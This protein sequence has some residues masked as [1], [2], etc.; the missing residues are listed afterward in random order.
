M[1]AYT[2]SRIS[3]ELPPRT[4]IHA[5]NVVP[6]FA[7]IITDIACASDNIPADTKLTV[8]TVVAVDD[9]TAAVINAPVSTPEKRFVVIVPSTLLSLLPAIFCRPSLITF[10]PYMSI[11]TEPI[12]VIICRSNCIYWVFYIVCTIG[13][14][15]VQKKNDICKHI[16]IFYIKTFF[17]RKNLHI[18]IFFCIFAVRNRE[19]RVSCC[20]SAFYTQ[21]DTLYYI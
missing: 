4:I 17:S 10:I 13:G 2:T 6:I 5:V 1:V 16:R 9:C 20:L 12:S 11:A 18:S 7:P 21:V 19:R 3:N 8:I 15:K 14:T